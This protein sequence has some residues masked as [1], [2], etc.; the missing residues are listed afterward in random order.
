MFIY[1]DQNWSNQRFL[2]P[3]GLAKRLATLEVRR[4]AASDPSGHE[5][6]NKHLNQIAA[7]LCPRTEESRAEAIRWY[8]E[9]FPKWFAEIRPRLRAKEKA[10]G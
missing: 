5:R 8:R 3:E 6:L 1:V 10:N 9:D 4:P 2:T 7:R